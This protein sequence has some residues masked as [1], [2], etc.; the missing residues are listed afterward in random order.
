MWHCTMQ[1]DADIH[2]QHAIEVIISESQ[3]IKDVQMR[4]DLSLS[5]MQS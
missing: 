5:V 2:D 1:N 3:P 4:F